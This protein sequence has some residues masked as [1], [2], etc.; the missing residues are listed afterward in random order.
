MTS[1]LSLLREPRSLPAG[2]PDTPGCQRLVGM[3]LCSRRVVIEQ[4][5]GSIGDFGNLLLRIRI[6]KHRA[7]AGCACGDAASD[8]RRLSS[9]P[10]GQ[11]RS[12]VAQLVRR[13]L[14][15]VPN[16]Q[17]AAAPIGPNFVIVQL[18]WDGSKHRLPQ[19]TVPLYPLSSKQ[20]SGIA[21]AQGSFPSRLGICP[22]SSALWRLVPVLLDARRASSRRADTFCV[23]RVAAPV[24]AGKR[25]NRDKW[26]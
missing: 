5:Y 15:G 22:S 1:S 16:K 9:S 26:T 17:D 3:C 24:C 13:S 11:G 20:T 12:S 6:V 4:Q 14:S 18:G 7:P 25:R 8:A 10:S 21:I 23:P 19:I 2:L